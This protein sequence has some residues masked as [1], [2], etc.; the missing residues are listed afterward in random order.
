[1]TGYFL[2]IFLEII[3]SVVSSFC[4]LSF[5]VRC[6]WFQNSSLQA[7]LSS[8]RIQLAGFRIQTSFLC[9]KWVHVPEG[10]VIWIDL[11]LWPLLIF[12]PYLYFCPRTGWNGRLSS[13]ARHSG[14]SPGPDLHI[15]ELCALEPRS[16]LHDLARRSRSPWMVVTGSHVFMFCW[17][18]SVL[19][20][21][22]AMTTVLSYIVLRAVSVQLLGWIWI[23]LAVW[24]RSHYWAAP[25]SRSQGEGSC[26]PALQPRQ[27]GGCRP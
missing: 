21:F 26:T 17:Y 10:W 6:L 2:W 16:D 15:L 4:H 19:Q 18:G 11:A 24:T 27:H 3:I 9:L 1:M 12:L 13:W 23:Y 14:R 5:W 22:F 7:Q 20:M 8:F 25:Q